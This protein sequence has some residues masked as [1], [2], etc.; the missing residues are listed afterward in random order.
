MRIDF[1][2]VITIALAGATLFG[3]A[4]PARAG[5]QI[6]YSDRMVGAIRQWGYSQSKRE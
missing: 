3:A 2:L 1:R 6:E 5:W 4:D